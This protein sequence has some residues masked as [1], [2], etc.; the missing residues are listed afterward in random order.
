M[1]LMT[2]GQVAR[3]LDLSVS[4]VDWLTRQGK[5]KCHRLG[6]MGRGQLRLYSS[7]DVRRLKRQRA[8]KAITLRANEGVR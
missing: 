1:R 4:H 2:I 5:L 8:R 6:R 3:E 7:A